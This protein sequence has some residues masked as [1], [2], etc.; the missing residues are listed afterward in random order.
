MGVDISGRSPI[1][2]GTKPTIDWDT[3]TL[4]EQE[5]HWEHLTAWK[6]E[7]P[8]SYF[9]A[10]WWSW[11]PIVM[12]V[13]HVARQEGLDIDTAS[14]SYNDGAGLESQEDC[15]ALADALQRLLDA[16]DN[17]TKEDDRIYLVMGSWSNL[18]GQFVSE[19]EL[20]NVDLPPMGSIMYSS[21]ITADGTVLQSSHST[22]K[23]HLQQ[24]INFLRECGGFQIF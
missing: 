16:N 23:E 8:G 20:E 7:N 10:N 1:N 19:S 9:R 17:L 12:L 6:A 14:W 22:S 11:R 2:R 24:F 5:L 3:A 18:N 15:D 4:E 13:D 21:F